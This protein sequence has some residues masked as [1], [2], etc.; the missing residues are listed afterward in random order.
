MRRSFSDHTCPAAMQ[1]PCEWPRG[2]V[3]RVFMMS[4]NHRGKA[5]NTSEAKLQSLKH[6]PGKRPIFENEN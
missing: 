5:C 2:V 3:F 4:Q 1:P 6:L